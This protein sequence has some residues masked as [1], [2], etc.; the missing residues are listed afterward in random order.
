LMDGAASEQRAATTPEGAGGHRS[1]RA[2][3]STVEHRLTGASEQRGRLLPLL[4]FP[5]RPDAMEMSA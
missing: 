4:F 5:W 1:G 2:P 3:R